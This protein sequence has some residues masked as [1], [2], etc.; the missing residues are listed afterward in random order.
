MNRRLAALAALAALSLLAAGCLAT[1]Q[2]EIQMGASYAAEINSKLPLVHDPDVN[3]YLNR[4]GDS[5]ARV[6]D[7]RNLEWHFYVVDSKEVNAFAVPGGYVYVNRGLIERFNKMD[8]LAS[9]LGHEIGHVTQRHS[10][11]QQAKAQGTSLGVTLGCVLTGICNAPG[12]GGLVNVG[13]GAMMAGFSRSDEAEADRVGLDYV[14]RAGIDPRGMPETFEILMAE[15]KER[16][17]GLESFFLT[18]PLEEDR[19]RQARA[20]IAQIPADR[21]VGLTEDSRAFQAFKA[22]VKA[23][24]P[25]PASK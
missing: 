8:Q 13:A 12:V 3:A 24:P 5:L 2:Q 15:R 20:L 17:E 6:A 7:A 21:L 14:V 25:S 10:I 23:L 11:K 9:V 1:Q 4:L 16:P 19:I 22:R 18:H